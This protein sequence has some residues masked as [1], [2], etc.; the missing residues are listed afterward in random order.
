M[1]A[2]SLF[3]SAA[4][5]AAIRELYMSPMGT[6]PAGKS[7][8]SVLQS[9]CLRFVSLGDESMEALA[10]CFYHQRKAPTNLNRRAYGE[11]DDEDEDD[12]P[13]GVRFPQLTLLDV[14]GHTS[15]DGGLRALCEAMLIVPTLKTLRIG[16]QPASPEA[17]PLVTTPG[18][19]AAVLDLL[20]RHLGLTEVDLFSLGL[21]DKAAAAIGAILETNATL[22]TLLLDKNGITGEGGETILR[23]VGTNVGLK[24]LS[25]AHNAIGRGR[26]TGHGAMYELPGALQLNNCLEILDL[27]NCDI[28]GKI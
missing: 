28:N 24:T 16:R 20:E 26:G 15:V 22:A 23:A 4:G 12:R 17:Q 6:N 2:I 13:E 14:S 7:T 8:F 18:G 21:D 10:T 11:H 3:L 9:L 25:L 27:T 1:S 5:M 19:V